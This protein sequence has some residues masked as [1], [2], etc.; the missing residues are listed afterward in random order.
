VSATPS[1]RPPV[2]ARNSSSSGRFACVWLYSGEY[3]TVT[4]VRRLPLTASFPCPI[5]YAKLTM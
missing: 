1:V 5:E 4:P 3:A 2:R